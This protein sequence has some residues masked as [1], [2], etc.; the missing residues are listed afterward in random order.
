[1]YFL[2]QEL[3]ISDKNWKFGSRKTISGSA[4]RLANEVIFH[5]RELAKAKHGKTMAKLWENHGKT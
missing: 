3:Y 1:L 4:M 5:L 2:S